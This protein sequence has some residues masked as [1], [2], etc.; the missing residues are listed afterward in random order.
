MER[1]MVKHGYFR[2]LQIIL[3]TFALLVTGVVLAHATVV[4]GTISTLPEVPQPGEPFVLQL[5]LVDQAQIPVEDAYVLAEFRPQ[6][7][8]EEAEPL[9]SATLEEAGVAGVYVTTLTLPEPGAYTLLLRDQTFRQEE[10]RQTTLINVGSLTPTDAL[11]VIFPP[12]ATQSSVSTWLYWL[13]GV[14][15]LAAVIVTVLVLRSPP[16]EAGGA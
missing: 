16:A 3:L 14:P 5:E 15:L 13:I 11:T 9:V 7:S 2:R 6:G 8:S 4:F 1:N 12:T 10:G